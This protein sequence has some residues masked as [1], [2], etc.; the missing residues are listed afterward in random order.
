[1]SPKFS[2]VSA[3]YNVEPYLQEFF[4]S[5]VDQSIGFSGIDVVLVDDGSTDGSLAACRRFAQLHSNVT[6]LTQPNQGQGAARNAGIEIA[7]G[8]WVTFVD[9]DDVLDQAYFEQ[10]AAVIAREDAH[11]CEFFAGHTIMWH[12]AAGTRV[13]NHPNAFRFMIGD[14][15][16]DL[17]TQPNFIHGQAPLSFFRLERIRRHELSFDDRLRTRFE[18]GKF[19][20]E[21]LLTLDR[22]LVGLAAGAHYHYRR[23]ADGSS[24]VQ[25]ASSDERTYATVARFGYLPLVREAVR[26]NGRVPRW[27]QTLIVYD[28]LWL[29]KVEAAE[30]AASR[31]TSTA[32]L[33]QFLLDVAETMAN[34]EQETV[35]GFDLMHFDPEIK[36]ALAHG[37][38]AAAVSPIYADAAD[39]ARGLVRLRYRYRGDRPSELVRIQRTIVHP[40]HATERRVVLFG[41]EFFTERVLWVSAH[42]VIRIDLDGRTRPIFSF[43]S[44]GSLFKLRNDAIIALRRRRINRTPKKFRVESSASRLVARSI[45]DGLRR[46]RHALRKRSLSDTLVSLELRAPWNRRRFYDAWALMDREWDANDS[47]EE[48]YRWLRVEHP[49]IN[50]WFVVSRDTT[51]WSRLKDDGFRLVP[52][53][54][55]R[56]RILMLMASELISSHADAPIVSPF[57]TRYGP[58]RWRFTFLQH[59]VIKGDLSNWLN[60]K[61]I[62][63]FVASTPDEYG[64]L[65]GVGPYRYSTREVRLTGLPRFDALKRRSE[66]LLESEI[67]NLLIAPTWRKYL[68]RPLD[69]R[70]QRHQRVDG[71]MQ[72]EFARAWTALLHDPALHEFAESRKL[73][74]VFLP[75]PN[76]SEYISEFDLPEVISTKSY[77]ADDVQDLVTR[78]AALITDYSSIAFNFAFLGRPTLYFQFDEARYW[79]EHTERRGY[80]DYREHGFGPVIASPTEAAG[81]LA[82][83][84]EGPLAHRFADRIERAFPF[85]DGRNSERVYDAVIDAGRPLTFTQS[86]QPFRPD[87]SG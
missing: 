69:V 81:G 30:H 32:V 15:I 27:L 43:E 17:E 67:R 3:V 26:T 82:S 34:V 78:S 72:S 12:E 56:Y 36:W 16:T 52:Y 23:R 84:F 46:I 59:G 7:S 53:G 29:T 11:D 66:A 5:L 4:E 74:I 25:G 68:S 48:F 10:I 21:Y 24:S 47:A 33:E 77:E 38:D 55:R 1:M 22:P 64:A 20:A 31:A 6:V 60:P 70:S 40:R 28:L 50:A 2:L 57:G 76:L 13:D 87:T 19:V 35:L 86:T 44:P 83:M 71:F 80:F 62:D 37:F 63:T 58:P 39:D 85:R 75:H 41:R 42:D 49:E 51:T 73:G 79:N 18:D 8:E 45:R 9:P 14:S 61:P 65:T 54:S